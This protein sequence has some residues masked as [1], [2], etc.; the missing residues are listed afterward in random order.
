MINGN[1]ADI[2]FVIAW[3]IIALVSIAYKNL[4][5]RKT[6]KACAN[7]ILRLL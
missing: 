2:S 5:R 7:A 4:T 3:I 6:K 1:G